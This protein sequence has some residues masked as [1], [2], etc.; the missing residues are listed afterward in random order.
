MK[1]TKILTT[2]RKFDDENHDFIMSFLVDTSND[3]GE[4]TT[5]TKTIL[6]QF[7]FDFKKKLHSHIEKKGL[8]I[9]ADEMIQLQIESLRQC[10]IDLS[11]VLNNI[12]HKEAIQ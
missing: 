1:Q 2:S 6:V 8:N 9:Q 4:I 3:Y 12:P 5:S 10:I 7:L 11:K